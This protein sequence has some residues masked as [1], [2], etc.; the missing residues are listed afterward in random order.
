MDSTMQDAELLV[1]DMLAH[2]AKVHPGARVLHYDP[3][4]TSTCSFAEL[5]AQAT[6]L[7]GALRGL[8]VERDDVV[9]TL[10]WNNPA[11]LAAY[12]A[13]PSMGAVLHTLNLRLSDEQ[14][15]YIVNHASDR[16]VLVD[17][18]LTP[19]LA[20][21]LPQCPT[22]RDVVVAGRPDAP[23]EAPGGVAVH[24]H[25]ELLAAA[26]PV[27][28]W[29]QLPERSAA[30][31]CYTTGTTGDPK[32]VAYSHRSIYLHTLTIST[33]SAFAFSDADRV[34]PIVPMFHANAWG[35]PYAA[36][37]NG[38]DLIMTDRYLQAEHLARMIS[39]LRATAAAAVPS[40]WSALD[41]YG[42]E[43]GIDYSSLR[44]A[45]S[46]GSPLS[47]A[48]AESFAA[49]HGV[50]LTQ[51]WGMTETSPLLTFSRPP[52]AAAAE[53]ALAYRTRTGRIVPGVQ[54]RAVGEHGDE[55]PW[56][57]ASAGE[58]ELRG[59]TIT[60][61]Y[62][63]ADSAETAEKFRDGWLRSGDLGVIH[64]SG[65][66]ELKD[67]L[68][69]GIKSG[70]EWISSVELENLLAGHPAVAEVVVIGVP[71]P[72][73][74][75]RPMVCVRLREG[76]E[77]GPAELSEFL[78]GKVARWWLPERWA[79]VDEIPK[80]SVGKLDKKRVRADHATGLFDVR[81]VE[82]RAAR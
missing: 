28:E 25:G 19:Q 46:G 68:K 33:G 8:G 43:R 14:L 41:A 6:L 47:P 72:R 82:D 11:H 58:I 60:G 51:G 23:L 31:L 45:V 76:A 74:E 12:F 10:C 67:R 32:G 57:G 66:V 77:V 70:G 35:W 69:D 52:A 16:V 29:P 15:V 13:V 4:G 56:D 53:Q 49:H 55:L 80:T 34:L 39:E 3:A 48:L 73:W 50:Q 2:G 54:A 71:D 38:A 65:W 18:D 21:I 61:T 44:L 40:L 1:S 5:A 22:V 17:A 75:E 78:A 37:I 63:R 81:F 36:W 9:A 24:D 42:V 30:A 20:R 62:F 79:F 59:P 7:A 26:Q 64:P 27:A